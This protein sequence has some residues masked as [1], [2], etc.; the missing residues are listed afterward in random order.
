MP[1]GARSKPSD[2]SP[3]AAR[4]DIGDGLCPYFFRRAV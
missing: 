1:F 4:R 3:E 2:F